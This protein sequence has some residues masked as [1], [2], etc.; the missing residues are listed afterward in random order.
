MSILIGEKTLKIII[1]TNIIT[2]RILR[3]CSFKVLSHFSIFLYPD[4]LFV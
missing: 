2:I 1:E 3:D 4:E